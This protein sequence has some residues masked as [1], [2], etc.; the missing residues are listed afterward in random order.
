MCFPI[1]F[2]S[3]AIVMTVTGPK[4]MKDV[5]LGDNLRVITTDGRV[6]FSPTVGWLHREPEGIGAYLRITTSRRQ[7]HISEEHLVGTIKGGQVDFVPAREAVVGTALLECDNSVSPQNGR[8]AVWGNPVQKVEKVQMKGVFAPL[9]ESGTIVVDGVGA[10]CYA[11]TRSHKAAHAAMKPMRA[12]YRHNPEKM[13]QQNY[14]VGKHI[15]GSHRYVDLLA[16]VT[17]KV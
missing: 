5:S 4:K 11:C 10:S 16:R 6:E 2:P 3:D 15:Q 14:H 12:M 1:C 7:V 17:G 13:R 9:T 8:V